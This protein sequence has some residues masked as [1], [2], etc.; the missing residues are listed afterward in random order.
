MFF[1]PQEGELRKA[2]WASIPYAEKGIRAIMMHPGAFKNQTNQVLQLS[3]TV[4]RHKLAKVPIREKK[5]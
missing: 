5:I 1:N 3:G 2:I 4:E